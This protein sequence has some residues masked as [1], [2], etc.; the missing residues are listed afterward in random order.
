MFVGCSKRSRCKAP[1]ESTPR[2]VLRCTSQGA[3]EE[4]NATDGSFSTVRQDRYPWN[5]NRVI[6]AKGSDDRV[7]PKAHPIRLRFFF[8]DFKCKR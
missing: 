4:G 3:D 5:L 8:G 6:P 2:D 7:N 1:D